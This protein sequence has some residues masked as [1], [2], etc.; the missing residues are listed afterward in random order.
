M[1]LKY[2]S[3]LELGTTIPEFELI[4]VL[5]GA[6]FA[7]ASL[8]NNKP[9]LIMVI[10]NHCPY[11]IQYHDELKRLTDDYGDFADLIAI[12]PNDVDH[13]PQDGPEPMKDL[14]IKIK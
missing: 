1:A 7:S 4:N 6:L 2:S 14:F 12:S 8:K 5:D 11:V 9:S 13:Y 10:C 3:M